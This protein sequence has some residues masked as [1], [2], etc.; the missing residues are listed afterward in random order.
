VVTRVL[1]RPDELIVAL[2]QV[3]DELFLGDGALVIAGE[4]GHK[5]EQRVEEVVG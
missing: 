5:E 4:Q 3:F 2:K 1:Y